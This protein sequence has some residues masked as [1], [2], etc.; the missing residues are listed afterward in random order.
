MTPNLVL[1]SG[2]IS[3]MPVS[4]CLSRRGLDWPSHQDRGRADV[5]ADL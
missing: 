1:P 3:Q 4:E 5:H 2:L